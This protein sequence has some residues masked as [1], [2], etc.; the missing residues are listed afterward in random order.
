MHKRKRII[1]IINSDSDSES[2]YS[3][4]TSNDSNE[5]SADDEESREI[6]IIDREGNNILVILDKTKK[7]WYMGKDIATILKFKNPEKSI[8]QFV[9]KKYKK[10]YADILQNQT[11]SKID[12]DTIFISNAGIFQL[13]TKSHNPGGAKLMKYITEKVIPTVLATEPHTTKLQSD[14]LN[15]TIL[16]NERKYLDQIKDLTHTKEILQ[17]KLDKTKELI[18]AKIEIIH[19]LKNKTNMKIN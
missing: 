2:I 14:E 3:D 11:S 8:T 5:N 7:A 13:V 19:L 18:A 9:T 10:S 16:P 15:N 6:T 17:I 4:D 1:D 12:P